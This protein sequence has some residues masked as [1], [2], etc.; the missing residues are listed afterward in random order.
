MPTI[1]ESWTGRRFTFGQSAT[2]RFSALFAAGENVTESAARA[3]LANQ[4]GIAASTPHPQDIR[5]WAKEPEVAYGGPMLMDIGVSYVRAELQQQEQQGDPLAEPPIIASTITGYQEAVDS[6]IDGNPITNSVGDVFE[7]L[8]RTFYMVS[9]TI[10]RNESGWDPNYAIQYTGAVNSD[11]FRIPGTNRTFYTVPA[12]LA[13]CRGIVPARQYTPEES[14]VPVSYNLDLMIPITDFEKSGQVSPWDQRLLDRGLNGRFT[15][16]TA[17]NQLGRIVN[18]LGEPIETPVRFNGDGVPIDNGQGKYRV[19]Q[20]GM[21]RFV[22][23]P[24]PVGA[25]LERVDNKACFL[26]YKDARRVS[27]SAL[28]FA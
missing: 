1:T 26:W 22:D 15:T 10:T 2:R 18:R 19:D 3:A 12:L 23:Q 5:L 6:D 28:G 14:W 21:Q 20:K 25:T 7:G 24:A 16:T 27:F 9:V 4:F 17:A 8:V 13:Y 11:A